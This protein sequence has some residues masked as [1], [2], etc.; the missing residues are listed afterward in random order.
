[1]KKLLSFAFVLL[2]VLS[3]V[4]A[5]S[6]PF[7][8]GLGSSLR[9]GS[10]TGETFLTGSLDIGSVLGG[11]TSPVS[12]TLDFKTDLGFNP[13]ENT[14]LFNFSILSGATV[15]FDGDF[16]VDLLASF[17]TSVKIDEGKGGDRF[18]YAPGVALNI[19]TNLDDSGVLTA[20]VG[21]GAEYRIVKKKPL[22]SICCG[23]K[24]GL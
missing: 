14:V 18:D 17:S 20:Y 9:L 16:F 22:F 5:L 24:M 7:T 13:S 3:S 21:M 12:F 1:M 11:R 2:L 23:M 15:D 10:G 19:G 6:S 8:V 4:F